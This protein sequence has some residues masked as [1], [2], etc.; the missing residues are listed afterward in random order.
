MKK[1]LDDEVRVATPDGDS[2]YVIIDVRYSAA[3]S[4]RL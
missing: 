2:D 1:T 3:D 4:S